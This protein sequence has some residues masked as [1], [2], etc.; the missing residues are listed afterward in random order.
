VRFE[1]S[2]FTQP[3]DIQHH[4]VISS[5]LCVFRQISV[6]VQV[7]MIESRN[8]QSHPER[9]QS[10]PKGRFTGER[11]AA[12]GAGIFCISINNEYATNLQRS[13]GVNFL[14]TI[15][16]RR[17]DV[18][19]EERGIWQQ[20]LNRKSADAILSRP[21]DQ[22]DTSVGIPRVNSKKR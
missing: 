11:L 20:R 18:H 5:P 19:S 10:K 8:G 17:R 13:S 14:K 9:E 2:R 4:I 7:N 22:S 1:P 3:F 21:K 16:W 12:S 15:P 6:N